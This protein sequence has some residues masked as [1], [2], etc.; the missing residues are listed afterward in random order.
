MSVCYR[1][2]HLAISETPFF[3]IVNLNIQKDNME[4]NLI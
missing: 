2:M 4:Y 3:I 1:E